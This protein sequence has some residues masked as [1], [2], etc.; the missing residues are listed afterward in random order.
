LVNVLEIEE[1]EANER[2]KMA[3]LLHPFLGPFVKS[4]LVFSASIVVVSD[5]GFEILALTCTSR[6]ETAYRRV[7]GPFYN[8]HY[9]HENKYTTVK[10]PCKATLMHCSKIILF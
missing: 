3:V 10:L 4:I 9:Y 8:N 2:N 7:Q 5:L 6:A 1:E